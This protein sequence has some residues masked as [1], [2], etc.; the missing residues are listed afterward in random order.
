MKLF[1]VY[2][3]LGGDKFK[4]VMDLFSIGFCP[5]VTVSIEYGCTI[6]HVCIFTLSFMKFQ[7]CILLV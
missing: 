4:A 1:N 3:Y 7:F 6:L 5:K 2:V